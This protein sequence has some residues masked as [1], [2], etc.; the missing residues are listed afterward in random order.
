MIKSQTIIIEASSPSPQEFNLSVPDKVTYKSVG[1]LAMLLLMPHSH[2]LHH[3]NL[4]GTIELE[5]SLILR[6]QSHTSHITKH[7]VYTVKRDKQS[8]DCT[9]M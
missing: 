3:I 5:L 6:P 7:C 8:T 4:L 9:E 2:V 1:A